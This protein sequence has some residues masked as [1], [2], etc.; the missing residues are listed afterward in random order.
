MPVIVNFPDELSRSDPSLQPKRI[1]SNCPIEDRTEDE[2]LTATMVY[3][4]RIYS[5]REEAKLFSFTKSLGSKRASSR[6]NINTYEKKR[7]RID[8]PLGLGI[9]DSRKAT[10]PV[11]QR[12]RGE[13]GCRDLDSSS[14]YRSPL[15]L[16][17][18][19][20]PLESSETTLVTLFRLRYR[21]FHNG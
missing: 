21:P 5:I 3:E 10:A 4:S 14:E 8:R 2:T 9:P 7:S 19:R 15:L 16:V 6:S 17:R 1:F 20:P 18:R 13:G 11:K 12:A